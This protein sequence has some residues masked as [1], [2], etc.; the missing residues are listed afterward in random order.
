MDLV[1]VESPTKAKTLSRYLGKAYDIQASM[2]HVRD[3]PKSKLGVDTEHKFE[4]VYEVSAGK[5]KVITLLKKAAK[6]A[7]VIYLATDPDREGEAI[8]Y[9]LRELICSNS[10]LKSQ[11]SKFRRVTFHEITKPA[12]EAA[13]AKPGELNMALVDAQQARRVV[14]RLV[15]YNLSPVLWRKV[16]RGLSAGRV[17]SVAVKLIV[18][19][20]KEIKVHKAQE[21]WTITVKLKTQSAKRK[22]I[23]QSQQTED[24]FGAELYEAEGKKI[25]I[26]NSNNEDKNIIFLD[27]E[28]VVGPIAEDLKKAEYKAEQVERKERLSRP[29][30]PYT[31][32]TLQQAAANVLG[33]SGKMT[34]SIAQD[35]YEAGLIT[36]HR[37]DSM[38]LASVAVNGARDYISKTY[39]KAYVPEKPNFYKTKAKNAQEAHEAIRPTDATV[40]SDKLQGTSEITEKHKKLYQLIWRRMISCQMTPAV[41]DATTITVLATGDKLHGSSY[42]LRA[43][44]S[45]V[46]FEG[47]RVIYGKQDGENTGANDNSPLPQV[48]DGDPLEYVD[49][50]SEQKFTQPMPRFN[51]ASL[52]KELEHKGIGR[53]STYAPIISTV[54]ARGYIERNEKRFY[55]TVIGET[56]TEFLDENFK[57]IMDYGFTAEMEEDLDRIALGEKDWRKVMA[58]FYKPFE[59]QVAKVTKEAKRSAIPVE[60]TGENCPECK[61]GKL[62]IRTGRFGKFIS[63]SRFPECKYTARLVQKLE[64]FACPECKG[65]VVLKRTKKGRTF[66]GCA[67]YPKCDY[68]SWKDPRQNTR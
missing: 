45:I 50:V 27:S 1:I 32:S 36:Y 68:A 59:K 49:L 5:T 46:K 28:K 44:G 16:R 62:V 35:L 66:W 38:S 54:I 61:E 19:R 42:K 57:E 26:K 33:W 51:D 40:T 11:N 39:G 18:E 22:T 67:N 53:P 31:T 3:L 52:V 13:L 24:T 63:C 29:Y 37:T 21:Y 55:P 20:E 10:K 47:W 4:P 34:M 2:G 43:A 8:A 25:E 41:Y 58:T 9:H 6:E 65:E 56:V 23:T 7:K 12:I 60:E 64:G 48:Q 14:D 15:G 30:P 17:Q